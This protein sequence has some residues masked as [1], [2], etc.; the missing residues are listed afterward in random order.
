[1]NTSINT[2]SSYKN[3]KRPCSWRYAFVAS[4]FILLILA[5]APNA[6]K[7]DT[8]WNGVF[9]DDWFNSFNWNGGLPPK[10]AN[11]TTNIVNGGTPKIAG[12]AANAGSLLIVDKSSTLTLSVGSLTAVNERLGL[13]GTGRFTQSGGT[14]QA[15]NLS[16]GYVV[17]GE[18]FTS[19]GTGT[20][21]L[22]GGAL[23]VSGASRVGEGGAGILNQTGGNHTAG[24]L[25]LGGRVEFPDGT[26]SNPGLGAYTLSDGSL[27]VKD[28]TEVGLS[29]KG[30]FT[31]DGGTYTTLSLYVGHAGI[32][33]S[34][35][36]SGFGD[37][38]Y[39]LNSGAL[40]VLADTRVGYVGNGIFNQT[41]GT[42]TV[43]DILAIGQSG[44]QGTYNLSGGGSVL[45]ASNE[46]IGLGGLGNFTQTNGT[47]TVNNTPVHRLV[48]RRSRRQWYLCPQR[49][50]FERNERDCR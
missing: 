48:S 23:N 19:S 27:T 50:E 9:S 38:S 44:G 33:P 32:F 49:G 46:Y 21:D 45:T 28:K 11:G 26:T 40:S 20:Y 25:I 37:G 24:L 29:G 14:N 8:D 18:G 43:S 15:T 16:I 17:L 5:V 10:P 39:N 7:A 1:M 4:S 42:H 30:I 35:N 34:G 3:N 41:G 2:S 36:F 22:N 31:Q 12:G 47:H 6:A 13:S